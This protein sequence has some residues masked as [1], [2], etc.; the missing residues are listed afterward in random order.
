MANFQGLKLGLKYLF[1][2][3]CCNFQQE[4]EEEDD[5]LRKKPSPSGNIHV[6]QLRKSP[7]MERRRIPVLCPVTSG[8]GRVTREQGTMTNFFNV[9]EMES[10]PPDTQGTAETTTRTSSGQHGQETLRDSLEAQKG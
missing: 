4:E 5:C 2:C 1:C 8:G 7:D 3:L 9:A 6:I 10:S